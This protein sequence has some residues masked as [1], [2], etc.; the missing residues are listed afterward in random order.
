[1]TCKP[2]AAISEQ[3]FASALSALT[4]L[5]ADLSLVV[6]R[7]GPPPFWTREPGFATLALIILE[8]QVSLA[9]ARAAYDR[10]EAATA[11]LT[12]ESLLSLD[13]E[14][15]RT[16]GFS[17]QKAGYA[18]GL[19]QHVLDG[20]L[21]LDNL[22]ELSEDEAY[23]QLLQVKG[24]GPW[25]AQVYLLMAL[26]RPDIWPLGDLALVIAMQGLKQLAQRPTA[27][28]MAALAEPWRPW[29]AVAARI[30][31]HHYLSTR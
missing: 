21:D 16:V 28:E 23:R 15:M 19:A 31:W 29:R 17:R 2:T 22:G 5:D 18:R 11:P 13:D 30:L 3:G 6:E 25:S 9:S 10:L 24:I 12:P 7:H 14:T 27:D 1:M 4:T 20:R 8:Q 26:R